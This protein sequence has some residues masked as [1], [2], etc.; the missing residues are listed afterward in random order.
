MKAEDVASKLTEAQRR[1][2]AG[3]K[4]REPHPVMPN[5]WAIEMP[6][7]G[8][9]GAESDELVKLGLV[10][11][12]IRRGGRSGPSIYFGEVHPL[13]LAVRA[14]LTAPDNGDG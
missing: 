8:M 2:L 9:N 1:A 6:C 11:L 7:C 14:L 5:Y 10:T 4:V 12:P 3:A 13:G